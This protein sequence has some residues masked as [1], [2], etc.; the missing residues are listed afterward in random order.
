MTLALAVDR[1]GL[2]AAVVGTKGLNWAGPAEIGNSN[3][4][5]GSA[6]AVFQEAPGQFIVLLVDNSGILTATSFAV[7][8]GST[9]WR[10]TDVIGT[11]SF[12]PGSAIA[13]F[14]SARP[15]VTALL[16]DRLGLLTTASRD[17]SASTS[18]WQGPASLGS[19]N[20]VPGSPVTIVRPRRTVFAALMVDQDGVLNVA[21]L[22]AADGTSWQGPVRLGNAS[23]VPGS[24]VMA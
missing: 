24:Q 17:L 2:L 5:P 23:L 3:L 9:K 19:G 11:P 13:V 21:T 6:G 15:V 1:D 8:V 16:I 10:G 12:V 22:D 4:V 18:A 7:S 20:L 14:L